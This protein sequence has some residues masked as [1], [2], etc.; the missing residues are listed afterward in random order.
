MHDAY[1]LCEKILTDGANAPVRWLPTAKKRQQ[2]KRRRRKK[3]SVELGRISFINQ[4]RSRAVCRRINK[5]ILCVRRRFSV[6][7]EAPTLTESPERVV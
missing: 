1:I 7:M 3:T 6:D 4:S 2:K 5:H